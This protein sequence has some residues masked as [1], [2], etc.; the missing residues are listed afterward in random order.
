MYS[1]PLTNMAQGGRRRT[2]TIYNLRKGFGL[3]Y[4]TYAGIG[5]S[6]HTVEESHRVIDAKA[7]F[8][9]KAA[10]V[11]GFRKSKPGME[12]PIRLVKDL[13]RTKETLAEVR[14]ETKEKLAAAAE[15][16][17]MR[18]LRVSEAK[19]AYAKD[20]PRFEQLLREL[21]ELGK[22]SLVSNFSHNNG[23]N[24]ER[25]KFLLGELVPLAESFLSS[26]DAIKA[27]YPM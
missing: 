26:A 25:V 10:Q 13:E 24:R 7:A 17:K 27:K 21:E 20:G 11:A 8:D 16:K 2:D 1:Y 18:D 14:E 12:V 6:T 19:Q 4:M 5:L 3:L 23:E 22:E 15:L 9:A